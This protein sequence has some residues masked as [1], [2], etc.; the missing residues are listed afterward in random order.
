MAL[1]PP[2]QAFLRYL[3]A[4]PQVRGRIRAGTDRTLL[5]SGF[6]HAPT[7]LAGVMAKPM[8]KE[9]QDLKASLDNLQDKDILTDVLVTVPAPGT[10]HATLLAYVQT[11]EAALPPGSK[12]VFEIWK[13]LSGIFAAN[14]V[15]KV[16]FLIGHGVD[17]GEKVFAATEIAILLRN[18][19][20]DPAT[21]DMLAYYD[22]CIKQ[23]SFD[24][25]VS[26]V[27]A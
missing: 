13:A 1:L 21:K 18:P 3:H 15:G 5:Y 22:R 9:L 6:I 2:A 27:W 20:V 19:N 7:A 11:V 17:P 26:L 14:A 23:G 25:G 16:S 4:N 12:D 8:W 24:I 10:P